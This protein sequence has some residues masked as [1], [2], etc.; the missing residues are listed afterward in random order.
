[1]PPFVV[2]HSS[3]GKVVGICDIADQASAIQ[4]F[5]SGNGEYSSDEL[6]ARPESFARAK[7][8]H[9]LEDTGLS[10]RE[11]GRRVLGRDVR[12]LSRYLAGETI[13][14]E[15]AEQIARMRVKATVDEISIVV[16]REGDDVE[17]LEG[18]PF[19]VQVR[20]AEREATQTPLGKSQHR[21]AVR[22]FLLDRARRI[23]WYVDY[24]DSVDLER[25]Q[26]FSIAVFV[27]SA[28]KGGPDSLLRVR[29]PEI[30]RAISELV[31]ESL[32]EAD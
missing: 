2:S 6:V 26:A 27:E 31:E 20:V 7:L 25:D 9:L 13:P 30:L 10:L 19:S 23:T 17:F 5:A 22:R 11:F 18:R 8:S 16:N 3:T 28:R 14:P 12:S 24:A 32:E 1:M 15:L 29:D 21:L 4:Y